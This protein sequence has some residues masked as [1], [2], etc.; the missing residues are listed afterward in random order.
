MHIQSIVASRMG[1]P[2]SE[3][4]TWDDWH[5]DHV[6]HCIEYLRQAILCSADTS[7]EGENGPEATSTG[8]GQKH[9]CTDYDALTRWADDHGA[10]DLSGTRVVDLK[11]R[12]GKFAEGVQLD[13]SFHY[14]P[15]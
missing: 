8:W 5:L 3:F 11:K 2:H 1:I 9:L 13:P 10:W 6:S 4:A 12:P 15:Q 14:A 7:L